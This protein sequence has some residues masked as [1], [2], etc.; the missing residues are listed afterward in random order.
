MRQILIA[1][2]AVAL[3]AGNA[4]ARV[5]GEP[6]RFTYNIVDSSGAHVT[7]QAP[8]V[9]VQKVSTGEW[10]DFLDNTFKAD[11]WEA[12]SA[13]LSEDA[14]NG[15]Y[16]YQFTPPVS[17][18]ASDQYVF[19]VDN[20]DPEYADHQSVIVDYEKGGASAE[21]VWKAAVSASLPEGS[22]GRVLSNVNDAT[23]GDREG[24][25]YTGIEKMIRVN[26]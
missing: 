12:K 13:A 7:G 14:V 9:M 21:D 11:G 20:T 22:A 6:Y 26:R 23:D 2:I 5:V 25:D 1:L 3:L 8:V 19:V 15:Y 10:L 4:F 18:T 16:F 24:P 17:E